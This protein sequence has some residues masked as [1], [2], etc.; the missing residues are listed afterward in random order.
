MLSTRQWLT[1]LFLLAVMEAS[2]A[3]VTRFPPNHDKLSQPRRKP[4]SLASSSEN[5][6]QLPLQQYKNTALA[7]LELLQQTNEMV[8]T[9]NML[10]A[11]LQACKRIDPD[12]G[13]DKKHPLS[14]PP[15]TTAASTSSR[16]DQAMQYAVDATDTYGR[17]S[18]QAEQAWAYITTHVLERNDPRS[19]Y[20]SHPSY[21][22]AY[23]QSLLFRRR[24]VNRRIDNQSSNNN[25]SVEYRVTELSRDMAHS[26]Q[27]M[28][29]ALQLEISRL[30]DRELARLS[31]LKSLM[32]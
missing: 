14:S 30:D 2:T 25:S 4:T 28:E 8:E 7:M 16:L 12:I 29:T 26:L 17:F 19:A 18:R 11:N 13:D 3:F 23:A 32:K 31:L 20:L 22:Y 5:E 10:T 1:F 15:L 27:E 21:R 9:M 24:K 6:D